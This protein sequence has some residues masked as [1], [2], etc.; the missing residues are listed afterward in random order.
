MRKILWL[1]ALLLCSLTAL[2]AQQNL[3]WSMALHKGN[4]SVSFSRPVAMKN[5][6]S[7]SL[8]IQASQA[9]YAYI[10]YTDP[11]G[12]MDIIFNKRLAANEVWRETYELT[13]PSGRETI[14]IVIS[15]TE[16]KDLQSAIS[17]FG[18]QSDARTTKDLNDAVAGA[19]RSASQFSENPEKPVGMGGAVRGSEI[20]G[21]TEFSGASVYVKTIVITH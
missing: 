8:S 11:Q 13:P 15:L 16:Q 20:T 21:G 2:F 19:R 17:A 10:V 5:G 18:K 9:C 12:Q 1:T 6:D 14:Q 3:T 4:E 7:F